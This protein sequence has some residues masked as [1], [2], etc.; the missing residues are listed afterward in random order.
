MANAVAPT[1][2]VLFRVAEVDGSA[3]VEPLW[4]YDLGGDRFK[5]DNSPFYAYGV[6]TDD[7]VLAPYDDAEGF[8][9]YRS[10][11]SKSGN[12]TVRI[13]TATMIYT[14]VLYRDPAF[15]GA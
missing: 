9:T 14:N 12:R 4:A 7:T 5:L 10:V 11:V 2:K 13:I 3:N 6:S 15:L 8:P 1:A